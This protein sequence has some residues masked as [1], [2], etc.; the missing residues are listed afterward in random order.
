MLFYLSLLMFRSL[1][2]ARFL[3]KLVKLQINRVRRF[4][5]NVR[6]LELQ[7]LSLLFNN[8]HFLI[9]SSDIIYNAALPLLRS[10]FFCF[11]FYVLFT[12][13]YSLHKSHFQYNVINL[14]TCVIYLFLIYGQRRFFFSEDQYVL[15]IVLPAT[16]L[17]LLF[18]HSG[19]HLFNE[20]Y[21]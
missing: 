11:F 14:H 4:C 5:F 10:L 3:V 15:A 16:N 9:L 6:V 8:Y 12:Y 17:L 2:Y 7:V 21:S 18:L 20:S 1:V 19:L 13:F